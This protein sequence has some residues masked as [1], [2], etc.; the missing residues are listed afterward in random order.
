MLDIVGAQNRRSMGVNEVYPALQTGMVDTVPASA[1]AAVSLQWYTRLQYVTQQ[2]SGILVGATIMRKEVFD[3]LTPE[4][5]EA[6][7]STSQRAHRA[8][9]RSV[10]RE[11][12]RAY[13]TVLRRGVTEVDLSPNQAE[14]DSVSQQTRDALVGRLYSQGLLDSVVSAAGD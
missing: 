2:N 6:L 10:R 13:R 9:R 14:W 5:Q 8:L 7:T 3:G 11:D 12:D 4:Q 1:L